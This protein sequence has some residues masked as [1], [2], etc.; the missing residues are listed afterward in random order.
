M[1]VRIGFKTSQTDVDWPTLLALW[2]LADQE[3]T[4]FDSGWIF[5]HFVSPR[6]GGGS[7]EGWTTLAALAARTRRLQLGHLVVGNTHRH[8]ALTAK[9]GA[10]LDHISAG[11][12]VL[13]LGAGWHEGEHA[14]YGWNLPPI[15]ERMAMLDAAVQIIQGMWRS[16]TSFSF[17]GAGYRVAAARCD[18]A[19]HTPDGPP[20]WL[21]TQGLQRGLR[22]VAER[23]QGWNSTKDL[24]AFRQKREVLLRH[25]EAVG[26]DPAEIEV[27]TKVSLAE[28]RSRTDELLA[29]SISFI[30]AGVHHLVLQLP[31]ALGPDAL[32]RLAHEV[33]EPLRERFG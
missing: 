1:S 11:R 30:E 17:E 16:P 10:A 31:P 3:L 22:I 9:M 14:M 6:H 20:V 19:P 12:F 28:S 33:A 29:E 7:H 13:G 2:E 26:R 4:V 8:P 32:K 18:P 21:G 25:C 5:D 23:A 15:G 27:S 24:A